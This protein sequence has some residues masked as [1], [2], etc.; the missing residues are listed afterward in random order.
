MPKKAFVGNLKYSVDDE[1]LR[2]FFQ[3]NAGDVINA[4]VIKDHGTGKPKGFGFVEFTSETAFKKALGLNGFMFLGRDLVIKE[5]IP[6]ETRP[7]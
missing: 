3:H 1:I 6:Q 4:R 2:E 5:A 7:R